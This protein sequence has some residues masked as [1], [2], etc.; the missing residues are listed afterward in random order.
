MTRL[1]RSER[2]ALCDLALRLGADEP[3]LCEGWT[4]KDLVVHLL[5]REGSPAAVGISVSRLSKLT[6]AASARIGRRPF[7]A[8]VGRL[9]T[10]PPR[11]SPFAIPKIDD[12]ANTLEFFVHHEDIR[13]AQPGWIPRD[14][15]VDTDRTLWS[16]LGIPGKALARRAP[17]GVTIE[18][19][20]TGESKVL[21][22]GPPAVTARGPA[23]EVAMFLFG[24]TDHAQVDLLG[25][26][27]AVR[28]LRATSLGI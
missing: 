25:D 21:S 3:T 22:D 7:D 15:G 10:G 23:G 8:L 28:R 9:R 11:L 19:S 16:M 5:V 17:V 12:L 18:D 4:V 26:V 27:D 20:T 1:A 24:R 14:L 2:T 13:R 6:D